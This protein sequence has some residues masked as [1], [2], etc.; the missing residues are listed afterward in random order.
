MVTPENGDALRERR[1]VAFNGMLSVAVALDGKG[2]ILSGPQI[3]AI[4]LPGDTDDNLGD[5][6]DDLADDAEAALKKLST[7]QRDDDDQV[8]SAISRAVKKAAYRIWERRPVV[9]TTVLRI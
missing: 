6:L 5:L 4:G 8:E 3:R 9:E 2:R 7:E 1:H